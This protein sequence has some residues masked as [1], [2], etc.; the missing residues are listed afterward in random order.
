MYPKADKN[1]GQHF[2]IDQNVINKITT[3]FVSDA[4]VIIEIGPGPG[5]LT[6][7]LSKSSKPFYAIELDRRFDEILSP[8]LDDGHLIFTDAL[9]FDWESF[10]KEKGLADKKIWLVSNLPYQVSSQ[11][12]ILFLQIPQIK[13]L[14]LMFQKEVAEKICPPQA[15]KNSMSSLMSLGQN[16]FALKPLIKAPPGCFRPQPK[17]DSLV[18]TGVRKENPEVPLESFVKFESFVRLL[19]SQK[20]KQLGSVLKRKYSNISEILAKLDI[21]TQIRAEALDQK[22]VIALFESIKDLK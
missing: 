7:K 4:E 20:R 14:T 8:I 3:N 18:L 11:L 5:V 16:Y 9:H 10:I 21:D 15:K 6:Q 12:F 19:F 22:R 17:V 13:Y 2:L 1:L